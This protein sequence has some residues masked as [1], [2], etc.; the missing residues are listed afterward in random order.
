MRF[1]YLFCV[2][3]SHICFISI[4]LCFY[5]YDITGKY[6]QRWGIFIFLKNL[7]LFF[8]GSPYGAPSKEPERAPTTEP[9]EFQEFSCSRFLVW[10]HGRLS[11][12]QDDNLFVICGPIFCASQVMPEIVLTASFFNDLFI[13]S[14]CGFCSLSFLVAFINMILWHGRRSNL[15]NDIS[16]LWNLAIFVHL[17]W[18][19]KCWSASFSHDILFVV[20]F[21]VVPLRSH[22]YCPRTS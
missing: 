4:L 7:V 9:K 21:V 22:S 1:S 2:L 12:F 6:K 19:Q 20:V 5:I 17:R 13:L 8:L 11:N 18:C 3:V 16:C 14:L 10:R 15:C